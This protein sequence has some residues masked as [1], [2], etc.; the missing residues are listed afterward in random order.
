M[1]LM[2]NVCAFLMM[3]YVH[4]LIMLSVVRANGVDNPL[5]HMHNFLQGTAVTLSEP[6]HDGNCERTSHGFFLTQ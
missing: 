1:N 2:K 3:V 6:G 4:F 5:I